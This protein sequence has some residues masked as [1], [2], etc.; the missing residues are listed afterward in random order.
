MTVS[1]LEETRLA[2]RFFGDDLDHEAIS[3]LLGAIPKEARTKGE[4]WQSRGRDVVAKTSSWILATPHQIP[5]DL[6]G[7]ARQLFAQ[8]T[9]DL[10]DWR[11]LTARY[12]SDLFCGL[13][14]DGEKPG[15]TLTPDVEAMAE[16]RGARL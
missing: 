12:K 3:R 15:W 9:P 16:E 13:F 2:L 5:G 10:A 8:L 1:R 7:Q 11:S 14:F 4:T 6:D